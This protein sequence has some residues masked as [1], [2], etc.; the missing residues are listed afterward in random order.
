MPT[1]TVAHALVR[2]TDPDGRHR[3]AAHGQTIDVDE[4]TAAELDAAGATT[5][6][7]TVVEIDTVAEG[8]SREDK[9]GR[10]AAALKAAPELSNRR[11]ADAIGVD[12]KTVGTIRKALE[13]SGEIPTP[14][15][16]S[17]PTPV[18]D[19]PNRPRMTA[20]TEKWITYAI[21]RGIDPGDAAA[22]PKDQLIAAIN[23]LDE[24]DT[25]HD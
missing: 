7:T 16:T 24:Q 19:T 21:A 23:Q 9:R 15:R 5:V 22:L 2:W 11:H 14:D 8:E 13:D 10:I 17:P 3:I 12:H 1:R 4:R 25:S 6:V 20:T 18:G